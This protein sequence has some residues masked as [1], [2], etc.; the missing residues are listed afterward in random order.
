METTEDSGKL[1]L[2]Q[3]LARACSHEPLGGAGY[4]Y[5]LQKAEDYVDG[6]LEFRE[7]PVLRLMRELAEYAPQIPQAKRMIRGLSVL[8]SHY[9][10]DQAVGQ[11]AS[12]PVNQETNPA[13]SQRTNKLTNIIRG[14]VPGLGR[15]ALP[16][17]YH[18]HQ[19]QKTDDQLLEVQSP[20]EDLVEDPVVYWIQDYNAR[21]VGN[22][23]QKAKPREEV[24]QEIEK[25]L[26]PV[27]FWIR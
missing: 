27:R 1:D 14:E 4:A 19:E 20:D 15:I 12:L 18:G 3:Q 10:P 26:L 23:S 5:T 13:I 7:E 16:P 24:I 21:Q 2:G 11:T 22:N 9:L 17:G 25:V 8:Y 6:L